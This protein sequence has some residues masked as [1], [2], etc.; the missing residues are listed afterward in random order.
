[1]HSNNDNIRVPLAPV[2]PPFAP[3][4]RL[5]THMSIH[6]VKHENIPSPTDIPRLLLLRPLVDG[7][8]NGMVTLKGFKGKLLLGLETQLPHL[9]DFLCENNLGLCG[10]VDTVGLDGNENTTADLEEET[11]V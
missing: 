6:L 10:T 11:G 9:L 3:R 8:D 5:Y 4:L 1:M 7:S 2:T